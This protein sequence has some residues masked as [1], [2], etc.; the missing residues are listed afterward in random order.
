MQAKGA[1]DGTGIKESVTMST[2]EAFI[3][4][5]K[6]FDKFPYTA[7]FISQFNKVLAEMKAE[8]VVEKIINE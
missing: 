7:D 3:G 5:T 4:V 1:Y 2:E 6:H 8:G